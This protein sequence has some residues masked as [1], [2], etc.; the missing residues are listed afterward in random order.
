MFCTRCGTRASGGSRYCSNCGLLLG[1]ASDA[2]PREV[3]PGGEPGLSWAGRG[4]EAPSAGTAGDEP[5]DLAELELATFTQRLGG[6]AIDL[7]GAAGLGFALMVM[8]GTVYMSTNEI[9]DPELLTDAEAEQMGLFWLALLT[10]IWLGTTWFFNSKGWTLGKRA[11]GLRIVSRD[12]QRPGLGRGLGRT[13]GAWLSWLPLGLGFLWASWDEHGQ[14][15]HD[16]MAETY[17]VRADSLGGH[18][19]R[20]TGRGSLH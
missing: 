17:V 19:E 9:T 11:V 1:P 3:A 6:F 14:T 2:E 7:A 12:G 15:W 10:P 8:V 18:H 5:L 13:L 4:S 16:K 20:G